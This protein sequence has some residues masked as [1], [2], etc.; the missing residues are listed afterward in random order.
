MSVRR[1]W[2]DLTLTSQLLNW[3]LKYWSLFFGR[4]DCM[5]IVANRA[6]CTHFSVWCPAFQKFWRFISLEC[7]KE[8]KWCAFNARSTAVNVFLDIQFLL[9]S[10]ASLKQGK[11]FYL[12]QWGIGSLWNFLFGHI[13]PVKTVCLGQ[14]IALSEMKRDIT[15]LPSHC[16]DLYIGSVVMSFEKRSQ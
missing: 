12:N 13:P 9:L 1:G 5:K 7:P 4:R 8:D 15:T 10:S 6:F 2:T 16:H 14:D 3:L 11:N